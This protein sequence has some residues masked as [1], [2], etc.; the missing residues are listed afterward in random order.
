MPHIK[1]LTLFCLLL[2][3]P[4]NAKAQGHAGFCDQA[5]SSAATQACLKKHLQSAQKRLNSIYKSLSD[6]LEPEKLEEMKEL[7]KNWLAYRDSE[8]MWESENSITP[9][10]KRLNELSCMARL[11][12]DRADILDVVYA[13]GKQVT[14]RKEYGTFPRWM[15]VLSKDHPDVFWG[16]GRRTEH[17]LNCDGEEEQIM[18]GILTKLSKT[19]SENPKEENQKLFSKQVV[20][21]IVENQSVGRPSATV[22]EFPVQQEAGPNAVCSDRVSLQVKTNPPEK[23]SDDN[24]PEETPKA[25]NTYLELN[26]KGCDPITIVSAGKD[27]AIKIEETPETDKKK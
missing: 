10:M 5:D 26:T 14:E 15:N 3:T 16:Y 9:S 17:D 2:F 4:I 20:L 7:Q 19:D 18:Q 25:C 11:T 13:D 23:K 8:C 21:A 6:K 12:E 27:F 22:L 1:I 24:N